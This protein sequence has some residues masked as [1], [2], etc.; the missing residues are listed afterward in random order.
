MAKV[1]ISHSWHD[2]DIAKRIAE[3]LKRDGADIWIDYATI[4]SGAI[5][6]RISQALEWCDTMVL[7][8]SKA[9]VDSYYVGLEWQ[10]A[11]DLQ[12]PIIPCTIDQTKR[13][14]ILRGFLFIDF[15][16]FNSAYE[17]L[18]Q[19]LE[20]KQ[21]K[22]KELPPESVEKVEEKRE[23]AKL[24]KSEKKSIDESVRRKK[25]IQKELKIK[26]PAQPVGVHR[27]LEKQNILKIVTIF[28]VISIIGT[29][30]LFLLQ[31]LTDASLQTKTVKGMTL[32]LIPGGTFDMGDTFDDGGDDEKPPHSV[33]V[34][35][36]Y[37]S[38]TEVTNAQYATFLN[39]SGKAKDNQENVMIYKHKWGLH[40]EGNLWQPHP[41]YENH[42][43]VYV[44][45]YG[46]EQFA[47]WASCRLPTEAEWEYAACSG[48]KKEK[49]AGTSSELNLGDFGWYYKNSDNHSHPVASKKSN[50]L[51]LYDLSGNVWEWCRDWY[52]DKYDLND[53]ND[54]KKPSSGTDRV[55][56]GGS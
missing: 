31:K 52:N 46:A 6:V 56:R 45:W 19:A 4:K 8:W 16:D 36:F 2:N 53:I 42:P 50:S 18:F 3:N 21:K 38:N 7:I 48:G 47:K 33:T 5:P 37:M 9:A 49:W 44:T 55:S 14:A 43:V 11:L 34:S 17:Q 35:D 13:P 20:I 15:R 25:E 10:S 54:P 41:G 23:P 27:V 26:P 32:V 12:K 51:G 30:G 28:I 39:D 22:Q 24:K 1:F 40:K 29:G